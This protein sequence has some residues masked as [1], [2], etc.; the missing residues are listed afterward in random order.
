MSRFNSKDDKRQALHDSASLHPQPD[1]VSDEFFLRDDFFDPR[2]LVQVKYEMLRR[3][4]T[5]GL[6][7]HRAA[8]SFGL[9]RPT[10]YHAQAAYQRDG[11]LGLRPA[12]RGPRRAHKLSEEV[13]AFVLDQL[14]ADPALQPAELARRIQQRLAL[15]VHPRSVK[16]A[17]ERTQKKATQRPPTRS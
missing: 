10:F 7:V 17:L 4:R 5:E 8:H 14:S 3:V 1:K 12:K 13:M 16:R 11:I 2:D 9:S 6:S 15:T